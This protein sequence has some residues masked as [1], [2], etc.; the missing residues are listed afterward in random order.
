MELLTIQ[1]TAHM[2]KVST[3]TVRRFIAD[4]RLPAVKVGK[5]VRVRKE[6][7]D[8]LVRPVKLKAAET[9]QAKRS[10]RP[11]TFDDPLF[12]LIG[13]ARSAGPGDVSENKYKYL[14]EA[15]A[16]TEE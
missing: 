3:V 15:Y 14:A 12:K 1:D 2:L 5:G 10:G 7:V 11:L 13:S 6:A 16:A 4:G 8:R 9:S